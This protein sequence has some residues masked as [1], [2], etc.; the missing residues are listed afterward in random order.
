MSGKYVFKPVPIPTWFG[1]SFVFLSAPGTLHLT[2]E[3]KLTSVFSH[4]TLSTPTR[5]TQHK[6]LAWSVQGDLS[7]YKTNTVWV[8]REPSDK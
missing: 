4:P 2:A 1:S 7:F 8:R 5:S 3:A 6:V